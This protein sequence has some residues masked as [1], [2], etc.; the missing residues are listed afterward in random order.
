MFHM[1]MI[2]EAIGLQ[3]YKIFNSRSFIEQEARHLNV[4]ALS[5]NPIGFPKEDE[6]F[7]SDM[8]EQEEQ[9]GITPSPT[10][11][12]VANEVNIN[13]FTSQRTRQAI[14]DAKE[15][16]VGSECGGQSTDSPSKER[17][18]KMNQMEYRRM[19]VEA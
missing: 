1:H 19:V 7:G 2:G 15:H 10:R 11:S 13:L 18:P 8:M 6:D 17:L 5:R 12:N 3:C 14:D 9:L 16:H 4:D